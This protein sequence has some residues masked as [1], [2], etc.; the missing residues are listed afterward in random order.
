MTQAQTIIRLGIVVVHLAVLSWSRQATAQ[1]PLSDAQLLLETKAWTVEDTELD[2]VETQ[3]VRLVQ[4]DPRDAFAHYLLAQVLSRRFAAVPTELSALRQATDLAEQAIDLAPSQEYGHLALAQ[5]LDQ[6]GQTDKGIELIESVRQRKIATSW[7]TSF[8]LARLNAGSPDTRAILDTLVSAIRSDMRCLD[9]VAPYIVAVAHGLPDDDALA[10]YLGEIDATYPHESFA[11]AR[12][13]L[14]AA[15]QRFEEA[16]ALYSRVRQDNPHNIPAAIAAASILETEFNRSQEARVILEPIVA[17]QGSGTLDATSRASA[18][19]ILASVH[20]SLGELSLAQ[21]RMI[22]AYQV[23]EQDL[24]LVDFMRRQY[25]K[26]QR[27]QEF[28]TAVEHLVKEVGGKGVLYAIL[29]EVYSEDLKQY[30]RGVAQLNTAILLNSTRG[31]FYSARGLIQYHKKDFVAALEDFRRAIDL[32]RG[33]ATA[34]YNEACMLSLLGRV[35]DAV[36]ALRE[37]VSIDPRL[38]E[39]A[40]RDPDLTNLR[41]TVPFQRLLAEDPSR[42]APTPAQKPNDLSH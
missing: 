16:L 35:D 6:M 10:S 31:D 36:A 24:R 13:S 27:A 29:G 33:D 17:A 25:R 11:I 14:L 42:Q 7:R 15:K 3:I 28:A 20:V 30:D 8:V 22:E 32:D 41:A 9:I 23:S 19:M 39:S 4:Q 1:E 26:H 5:I 34:H 2:K 21:K 18:L 40:L 37:A 12:A 38:R